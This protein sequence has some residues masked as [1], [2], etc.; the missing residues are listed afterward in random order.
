MS[1]L[2]KKID[3]VTTRLAELVA[4]RAEKEASANAHESAARADRLAMHEAKREI[5]SLN[6][7]LRNSNVQ[8]SVESAESAA[9]KAQTAAEATLARLAEKEKAMDALL[10]KAAPAPPAPAEPVAPTAA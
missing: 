1:D 3:E 5:E 10:A 6:V 7:V 4:I 8:R 9:K 2:L